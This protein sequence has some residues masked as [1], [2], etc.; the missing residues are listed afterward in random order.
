M[1]TQSWTPGSCCVRGFHG[2]ISQESSLTFDGVSF[3]FVVGGALVSFSR[4]EEGEEGLWSC[5][6]EE[7]S[8]WERWRKGY[9]SLIPRPSHSSIQVRPSM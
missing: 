2:E 9:I 4:G 6:P 3:G 1:G 5:G 7:V 8:C